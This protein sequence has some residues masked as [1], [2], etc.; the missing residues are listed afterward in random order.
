M[1]KP[2]HR[3]LASLCLASLFINQ[4]CIAD[5]DIQAKSNVDNF[6]YPAHKCNNKPLKPQKPKQFLPNDD[7]ETYNN[8]ISKYNINVAT[9]NE[10]IKR[11]KSCINQYIKNGNN[12]I[13]VI[14]KQ[15]N[16]ALKEA[17]NR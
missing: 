3:L 6:T 5:E 12:D 15:L 11:Y 4:L 13:N 1:N 2:K 9:Y 10:Q 7:I 17:R 14:K 8:D 16:S